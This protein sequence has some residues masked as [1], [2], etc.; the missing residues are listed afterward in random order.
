MI[1]ILMQLMQKMIVVIVSI[2]LMESKVQ[3]CLAFL[4]LLSRVKHIVVF[5]CWL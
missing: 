1:Q 3:V 2:H 5:N 4:T